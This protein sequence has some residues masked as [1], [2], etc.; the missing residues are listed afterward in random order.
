MEPA[1][2]W[3]PMKSSSSVLRNIT[4]SWALLITV[5]ICQVVQIPVALKALGKEEF[6]LFAVV[7]QL[8]AMLM[9][10][11]L[12]VTGAFSRLLIDGIANGRDRYQTVW[13]SGF[14]LLLCQA[15][16]IFIAVLGM[17]PFIDNIFNIPPS[18][19]SLACGLFIASGAITAGRY[20]LDIF[21][22]TLYAN[23]RLSVSNLIGI[24]GTVIQLGVFVLAIRM[25]L[26]LWA[27]I[28]SLVTSSAFG[29][30]SA[31]LFCRLGG[32]LPKL[33]F[34]GVSWQQIRSIF[35][36]GMDVIF[37]NLFNVF[38]SSAPLIFAGHFL[39]L[40][41]VAV[42]AVNLK[43]VS[44]IYQIF[45]RIPGGAEPTLMTMI[46]HG[47]IGKF[48]FG[49]QVIAKV[50][51]AS[52][53]FGGGCLY[54]TS[55]LLIRWWTSPAMIMPATATLFLC[56]M[57]LRHMIH[58]LFVSSLVMFKE[59]RKVRFSLV[60]EALV[61]SALVIVLGKCF[62]LPGLL[63]GIILSLPLGAMW[64]GGY[65]FAKLSG[66][67][68]QSL[69]GM[70]F[71]VLFVPGFA[72]ASLAV[73]ATVEMRNSPFQVTLLMLAW[74]AINA[75]SLFTL[76]IHGNERTYLKEL[77]SRVFPNAGKV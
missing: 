64:R 42:L 48:R 49:W 2:S 65:C 57:P 7:S 34:S 62:G 61:Y 75:V 73:F 44:L 39:T 47:E 25:G 27:Y 59:I 45:H 71:R 15:S 33:N 56:L 11:E 3:A 60:L 46:S 4:S 74:C 12:G 36:L 63:G 29:V 21:N 77:L 14:S 55:N 31:F 23:Q 13:A 43:L 5:S 38:M 26:G 24:A 52:A 19:H 35:S 68:L 54:I 22:I 32:L 9:Y 1:N 18:L 72:F 41:D 30:I 20:A 58:Y 67:T 8:L 66:C 17:A 76:A 51:L 16:V 28:W 69:M 70:V 40:Q 37:I 53:L 6:G 10:V 50:S